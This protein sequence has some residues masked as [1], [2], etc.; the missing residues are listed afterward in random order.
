M[1]NNQKNKSFSDKF[2]LFFEEAFKKYPA[3][4]SFLFI[5]IMYLFMIAHCSF[6]GYIG[7]VK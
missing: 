4:F 6:L 1:I 7:G 3:L 2:D 5:V